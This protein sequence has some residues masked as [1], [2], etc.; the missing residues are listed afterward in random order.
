VSTVGSMPTRSAG[1]TG[2]QAGCWRQRHQPEIEQARVW[3]GRMA[4]APGPETAYTAWGEL[5]N[6]HPKRLRTSEMD[7]AHHTRPPP[8]RP[9][10]PTANRSGQVSALPERTL[11]LQASLAALID[12]R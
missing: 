12:K 4:H 11:S 8:P 1:S 9:S 2:E 3:P 6:R 10:F 5:L 7:Q